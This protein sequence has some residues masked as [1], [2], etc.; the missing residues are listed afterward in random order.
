[1]GFKTLFD[2][3]IEKNKSI[4]IG[5]TLVIGLGGTGK[6]ILLRLRRLIVEKHG[7]LDHFPCI[8]FL[9]LD[10]DQ[11]TQALQQYDKSSQDD[12]LYHKVAFHPYERISLTIKEGTGYYIRNIK[13]YP[14]IMQWFRQKGKMA[15]LGELGEGASQVRMASRLAFYSNYGQIENGL[16]QAKARL[17]SETIRDTIAELGFEFDTS[18]WNIY[19]IA[20]LAGGTGSGTFI[21]MGFLLKNMFPDSRRMGIFFLPSFFDGYPGSNRM[22]ANGYAALMELNHYSFGHSFVSNWDIKRQ[23][24][25]LPPP[26]EY[27]YLL[28][29]ENEAGEGI[30]SSTEE[31]SMYQMVAVSIFHDFSLSEFSGLKRATRVNLKNFIDNAYKHNYWD[32]SLGEERGTDCADFYTTRFCSYGLSSISFPVESVHRACACR[33]ANEILNHWQNSIIDDPFDILFTAF[34]N[35]PE[36][37]MVQGE[38]IFRETKKR[39]FEHHIEDALLLYKTGQKFDNYILNET[40]RIKTELENRITNKKSLAFELEDFC[41]D[42]DKWM[43]GEDSNNENDWGQ[44]IRILEKNLETY[45]TQLKEGIR[46]TA[47]QM[48]NNPQFGIAYVLSILKELKQLMHNEN[49]DYLHYFNK[50]INYYNTA[51]EDYKSDLDQLISN[52]G[53][54]EK[55]FIFRKPDLT[56]DISYLVSENEYSSSGILTN[57]LLSRVMKQVSKRGK[58]V[59]EAIDAFLG[60]DNA[61]GGGLLAEYHRLTIDL[62]QLQS[63]LSQKEKYYSKNDEYATL[64]LLYTEDDIDYW[65]QLWMGKTTYETNLNNLSGLILEKVFQS[66]TVTQALDYITTHSFEAIEDQMIEICRLFF[67][68]RE[69]QPSA[70]KILFDDK[71][72]SKQQ[73]MSI[74]QSAYKRSKVWLKPTRR[75]GHVN[76]VNKPGERGLSSMIGINTDENLDFRQFNN[77]VSKLFEP[78]DIKPQFKNIGNTNK[79]MIVFYNELAGVPA[80]YP[81]SVTEIGGL[82]DKYQ[83]FCKNPNEIDPKNQEEVHIDKNRFQ[84]ADIIPKTPEEIE[85]RWSSVYIFVLARVLGILDIEVNKNEENDGYSNHYSYEYENKSQYVNDSEDLGNEFYALEA[86]YSGTR[87]DYISHRDYLY[88]EVDKIIALI[89]E[90]NLLPVYLLLI[91]FYETFIYPEEKEL[92]ET[93]GVKITRRSLFNATLRH[94]MVFRINRDIVT[95][96]DQQKQLRKAYISLRGKPLSTKPNLS[97]DEYIAALKKYVKESGKFLTSEKRTRIEKVWK[98]AIVF[99]IDKLREIEAESIEETTSSNDSSSVIPVSSDISDAETDK[100]NQTRACKECGKQINCRAIYCKHCKKEIAK[101]ITCPHCNETTVPDDLETCW[102][103]GNELQPEKKHMECPRCF[104]IVSTFP[105]P[106]CDH[107]PLSNA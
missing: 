45:L 57:Y 85:T 9:H 53:K 48:A 10:T 80:F 46:K 25:I 70:L 105:C 89:K 27:T 90:K 52:I 94:E 6:E 47:S 32:G 100:K 30:G 34:L 37:Q 2:T 76:I 15:D 73:R 97:Y 56:H 54:H 43:A 14:N 72:Y 7:Q 18:I 23:E 106:I 55:E 103:C 96:P 11:T 64:K 87:S 60:E 69:E 91:E 101:H 39:I 26:F 68:E 3:N 107:D 42:W 19:V 33:L 20:S 4:P 75:I 67:E 59:C 65:Y 102:N 40:K 35:L 98:N 95:D 79:S 13:T 66:E 77:I 81:S 51:T 83:I 38:Y 63:N 29:G 88:Q 71:R 99:D 78:E 49:Y 41:D 61:N 82:K 5:K 1:M 104:E 8:Q 62:I 58:R 74:I 24:E 28:E 84:F 17:M 36:I 50:N 86:I 44:Y 31:Y 92:C 22:K 93:R 21:D 16:Q 12:P